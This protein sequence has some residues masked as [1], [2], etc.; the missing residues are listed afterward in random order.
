MVAKKQALIIAFLVLIPLLDFVSGYLS[1]V[2]SLSPSLAVKALLIAFSI[3]Y[4]FRG[5]FH[6]AYIQL[7]AISI[8]S[9]VSLVSIYNH[10]PL[11]LLVKTLTPV[12]LLCLFTELYSY[13]KVDRKIFLTAFFVVGYVVVFMNAC[14]G[15]LGHGASTYD[16]G[17]GLGVKGFYVSGNE[18]G[19]FFSVCFA[20]LGLLI[21]RK[22]Y[23]YYSLFFLFSLS[24]A[25]LISTKSA[26]LGVL[27][28]FIVFCFV[29]FRFYQFLFFLFCAVALAWISLG[30]LGFKVLLFSSGLWDRFVWV[31]E[32]QGLVGVFLSGRQWYLE[33]T[34]EG[35]AGTSLLLG[36]GYSGV[37]A[38]I[39]KGSVEMDFLDVYLW[40]GIS[41]LLLIVLTLFLY[42]KSIALIASKI[43]RRYLFFMFIVYLFQ[44][45][46]AGH[47]FISGIVSLPL[48]ALFASDINHRKKKVYS[49]AV[50][51]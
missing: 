8:F 1:K 2:V 10:V 37:E 47:V 35:L 29:K 24:I 4:L 15:L 44:A 46:L 41:G 18:L 5:R 42:F 38:L 13:K 27:A 25:I 17:G 6:N 50:I 43:E 21:G 14:L 7:I 39:G 12:L 51:K 23:F 3:Y 9:L 36:I 49:K 26:I 34:L 31:F 20:Y 48:A 28:S 16:E 40:F 45:V 11:V 32:S 22:S 33:G 19:T 30:Q